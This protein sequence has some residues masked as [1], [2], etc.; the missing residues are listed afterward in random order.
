MR[1]SISPSIEYLSTSQPAAGGAAAAAHQGAL[2]ELAP[3]RQ[4]LLPAAGEPAPPLETSHDDDFYELT[5]AE[6]RAMVL[7]PKK[8]TAP[9]MQTAAMRE[10]EKLQA[11][12]CA[13]V[14]PG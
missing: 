7:A 3:R 9:K 6:L 2:L 1:L 5:E 13:G 10:L 4:V 11:P 12:R 14:R 8:S